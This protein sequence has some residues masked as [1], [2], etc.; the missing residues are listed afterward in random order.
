M[1]LKLVQIANGRFLALGPMRTPGPDR[2]VTQSEYAN[3]GF[4]LSVRQASDKFDW[5]L[6]QIERETGP[7]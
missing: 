7:S 5:R 1:A 4:L 2:V 6:G 3:D